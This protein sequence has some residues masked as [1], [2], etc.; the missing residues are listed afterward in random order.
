METSAGSAGGPKSAPSVL[1][2]DH[3]FWEGTGT[4]LT[5]LTCFHREWVKSEPEHWVIEGV[6]GCCCQSTSSCVDSVDSCGGPLYCSTTIC[7]SET[8]SVFF[9]FGFFAL[10]SGLCAS[11]PW[12][13]FPHIYKQLCRDYRCVL[14]TSNTADPDCSNTYTPAMKS[15]LIFFHTHQ[16][17]PEQE[18][19]RREQTGWSRIVQIPL[20]SA[21]GF[22]RHEL[23]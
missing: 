7:S 16:P 14:L 12:N 9:L 6:E 20:L 13:P 8:S 5:Q 23:Q 10:L 21:G 11:L 18:W 17:K 2:L 3:W 22:T 1:S 19:Q 15:H 4:R